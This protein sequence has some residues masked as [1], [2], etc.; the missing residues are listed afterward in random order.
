MTVTAAPS[1]NERYR[2][3]YFVVQQA[4]SD[5]KVAWEY[6]RLLAMGNV[7]LDPGAVVLD[8]ACG[9]APGLRYF[10]GRVRSAVGVDIA[11]AAL[12]AAREMLP[13]APLVRA[14]LDAPLPF[15]ERSFDAIILREAIEHVLDGERTL[16]F[17]L[18]VLR[19][20]GVVALTTPNRWDVR[21]PIDAA[22]RRTWCGDADPTHTHI[23]S[24]A[25]MRQA[26]HRAGFDCVRVRT[27]FKPI[28]RIGGKRLPRRIDV[29][30]P[31][32][33]GN[34]VVAFGWRGEDA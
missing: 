15:R 18:R 9:A 28:V 33:I 23:Y 2:D 32:L 21:R 14:N 20:G 17:C 1:A 19:P 34:G 24:P 26:L 11:T 31:P 12:R 3:E 30:Y 6:E 4:K 5:A 7:R 27:G 22:T 16:R 10:T 29:P 8:G 25:E 13:G